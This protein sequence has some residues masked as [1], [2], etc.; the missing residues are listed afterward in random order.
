MAN[1][2]VMVLKS[3]FIVLG[4]VMVVTLLYTLAIDGL[5]FRKDLLTPWMNATLL[6]FY[7]NIL[8]LAVWVIY[9]ESSW[10]AAVLWVILLV[11][12]GS[13]TTCAYVTIQLFKL[14]TEESANDPM[15]HL[16]LR[17]QDTKKAASGSSF[18]Q[19]SATIV[20]SVL[21]CLMLGTL[22]YTLLTYGS[23]FNKEIFIPWMVATLI[24]FYINVTVLSVW[25][26]YK[27]PNWFVTFTWIVLLICFGSIVTCGYVVRQLLLLS[28]HDPL[29]LVLLNN[30]QRAES[31]YETTSG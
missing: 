17:H 6:D 12:F 20:F 21:G 25:V 10:L 14:T 22:L 4:S 5:P 9:K 16:L 1:S 18:Q 24:D 31:K 7:I 19:I 28:P 23:P 11:C 2:T 15:Y 30:R 27:E 29:Y 8:V 26:G 13:I 3:V